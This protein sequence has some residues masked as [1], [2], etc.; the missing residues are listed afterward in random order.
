M[1]LM[2]VNQIW[3]KL[4]KMVTTIIQKKEKKSAEL[5]CRR[6]MIWIDEKKKVKVSLGRDWFEH[7]SQNQTRSQYEWGCMF[8]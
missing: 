1:N 7:Y 2:F 5:I 8:V 4:L 3:F 6:R